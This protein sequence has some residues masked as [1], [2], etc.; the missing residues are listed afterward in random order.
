M[1]EDVGVA[2]TAVV[3][4]MVEAAVVVMADEAVEMAEEAVV[5]EEAAIAAC[6]M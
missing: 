6:P 4:S 5:V 2:E 1:V 3:A